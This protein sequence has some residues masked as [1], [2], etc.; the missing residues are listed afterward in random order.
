VLVAQACNVGYRPFVDESNPALR[1]S[2][3]RYVAQRY[4]RPDTIAAANAR[5]VDYHAKLAL[6]E[7]WGGE[8]ASVD[9]LRFVVPRRTIH[10]AY[11]RRYFDRRR[12]ITALGATADH[13]AGLRTI[14]IPGTQPDA[15]YVLDALL[16]PLRAAG[17]RDRHSRLHRHH[18]R[19]LPAARLPVLPKARR[20]RRRHP[21]A[22]KRDELRSAEPARPATRSTRR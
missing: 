3:L 18:V 9:G 11:N 21:L 8:V 17:D 19:A 14:V 6:A 16:D 15:P 1:E 5:I 22:A 4:L 13:Y 7:R 12:G 2:R 20:H 10:A